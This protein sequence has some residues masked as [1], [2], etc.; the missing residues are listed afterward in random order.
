MTDTACLQLQSLQCQ[1]NANLLALRMANT[2][3]SVIIQQNIAN[4]RREINRLLFIV[5]FQMDGNVDK[6]RMPPP[7]VPK[8]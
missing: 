4:L 3:D 1:L 2:T 5:N 7:P 6:H 8:L